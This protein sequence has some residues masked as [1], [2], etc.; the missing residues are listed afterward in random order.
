[1]AQPP[2][3]KVR[4]VALNT[5]G[6]FFGLAAVYHLAAIMWR[7]LDDQSSAARHCLFVFIDINVAFG[8]YRRPRFF[9]WL[10][11]L[12]GLQQLYSHGGA[13]IHELVRSHTVDWQ[14]LLVL[15]IFPCAA[16]LLWLERRQARIKTR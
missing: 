10:F 2:S 5:I 8:L 9:F 16:W 3:T 11:S 4:A 15:A 13:F 12:L 6:A 14:S 1:M 7:R